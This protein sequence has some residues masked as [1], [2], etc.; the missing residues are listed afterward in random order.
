MSTNP[1]DDLDDGDFDDSNPFGQVV[2]R[3]AMPVP[4][5][6]PASPLQGPA[7]VPARLRANSK[8]S[9]GLDSSIM[10]SDVDPNR[11]ALS[12]VLDLKMRVDEHAPAVVFHTH[13]QYCDDIQR[14]L[15]DTVHKYMFVHHPALKTYQLQHATSGAV[16]LIATKRT[17][18]LKFASTALNFSIIIP[19]SPDKI[20]F[21]LRGNTM[22][23]EFMLFDDGFNPNKLDRFGATKQRR[24]LAL[25]RVATQPKVMSRRSYTLTIPREECAPINLRDGLLC[26]DST[27]PDDVYRFVSNV[28]GSPG[29]LPVVVDYHGLATDNSIKNMILHRADRDAASDEVS[30]ALV[31]G[32]QT[33]HMSVV[34]ASGQVSPLV[35]FA[36]TLT[37]WV[38]LNV[39]SKHTFGMHRNSGQEPGAARFH[40]ALT[41]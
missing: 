41:S 31:N 13:K 22:G 5:F 1:F 11:V 38:S 40:E 12:Y 8:D 26:L 34:L 15:G 29:E 23:S 3:R 6:S 21:K 27:R 35:A 30:V 18:G 4:H 17:D 37:A 9:A 10:G 19:S 20:P 2:E 36:T 28:P 39:P 16:L 7:G 33:K 25:I 32:K 24:E 14:P